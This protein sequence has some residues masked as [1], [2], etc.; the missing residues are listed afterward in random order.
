MTAFGNHEMDEEY[1]LEI[2]NPPLPPV[3]KVHDFYVTTIGGMEDVVLRDLR[4]QLKQ[5]TQVKVEKGRRIG[6]IF[7]RYKRSPQKLLELQSVE[8][9]FVLL[10]DFGGVTV[11]QPGLL[12]IAKQVGKVDLIPAAVLHDILHGLKDQASF[13]LSCTAG[14]GHRFSASELHH[15][16]QAV[17]TMKYDLDPGNE[18]YHLH[19]QVQGRRALLGL[20]LSHKEQSVRNYRL[21]QVDGDLPPTAAY[22]LSKLAQIRKHHVCLDARCGGGRPWSK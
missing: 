19:L 2:E 10:A 1:V 21:I 8:N 4:E 15:M 5:I 18:P 9:V 11:G 20:R 14:K 22:C 13:E 7:F 3:E 17:L 16:V 12:R 6:R